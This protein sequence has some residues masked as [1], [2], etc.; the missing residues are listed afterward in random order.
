M[1]GQIRLCISLHQL[2]GVVL[3]DPSTAA[4]SL[5]SFGIAKTVVQTL[6]AVESDS[7]V[8]VFPVDEILG[9]QKYNLADIEN[10]PVT[11]TKSSSN[12]VKGVAYIDDKTIGYLDEGLIFTSLKGVYSDARR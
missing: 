3:A 4:G 7:G 10:V 6:M 2:L 1:R 11:V 12:F 5:G 9:V 8:W